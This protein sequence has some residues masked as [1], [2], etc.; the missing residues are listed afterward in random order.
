[1]TSFDVTP[2]LVAVIDIA[3]MGWGKTKDCSS[4]MT[5]LLSCEK[6]EMS[7]LLR[8]C[9]LGHR[10][11]VGDPGDCTHLWYFSS[12]LPS[13]NSIETILQPLA[14]SP[15]PWLSDPGSQ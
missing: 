6:D 1:M 3:L 7:E 11:T 5:R 14:V 8:A 15:A 12:T 10:P 9:I 4:A 13:Y 2:N